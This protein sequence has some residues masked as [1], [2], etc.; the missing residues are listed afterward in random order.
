M[1]PNIVTGV[2]LRSNLLEKAQLGRAERWLRLIGLAIWLYVGVAR[3][4]IPGI[5][6]VPWAAYGAT[7]VASFFWKMPL[8]L[9]AQAA[10]AL[11][12]SWLGYSGFEGLLLSVVVAQAPTVFP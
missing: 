2:R 9:A 10:A 7:Y 4:D 12:M 5:W 8:L 1:D 6:L 11:A 3:R